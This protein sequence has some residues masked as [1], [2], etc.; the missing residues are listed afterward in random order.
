M[1]WSNGNEYSEIDGKQNIGSLIK[2]TAGLL[3]ERV[4][5]FFLES[6]NLAGH[7]CADL[8]SDQYTFQKET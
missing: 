4:F 2:S 5:V 1:E 7:G 6:S 3:D 8:G